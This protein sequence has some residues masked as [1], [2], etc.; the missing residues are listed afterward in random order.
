MKQARLGDPKRQFY[1]RKQVWRRLRC[2][3]GAIHIRGPGARGG[4]KLKN[5]VNRDNR[6][7][8]LTK[9]ELRHYLI[10]IDLSHENLG[11]WVPPR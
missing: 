8:V 5:S 3:R 6:R 7:H 2:M 11:K 9:Q 4:P 1:T 10:P